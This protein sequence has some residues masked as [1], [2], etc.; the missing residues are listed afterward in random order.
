MS[1]ATSTMT[2]LLCNSS[3]VGQLTLCRSSLLASLMYTLILFMSY[4]AARVERLEL[5]AYGFGD[6][7]S[8]N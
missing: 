5:P 8:A 7:R 2:R 4:F 6:H 1:E 3:H